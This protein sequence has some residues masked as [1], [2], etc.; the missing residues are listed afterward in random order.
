MLTVEIFI[1]FPQQMFG[2]FF[3]QFMQLINFVS[4]KTTAVLKSDWINPKFGL[5]FFSLDMDMC[6][7]ITI[8]SIKK[9]AIRINF[10]YSWHIT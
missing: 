1:P 6:R 2:I 7:F 3:H 8:T 10:Q 4:V 9:E 5:I